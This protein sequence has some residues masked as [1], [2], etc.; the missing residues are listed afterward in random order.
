ML[1]FHPG[2]TAEELQH[3]HQI[4]KSSPGSQR[5]ALRFYRDDAEPVS[6]DAAPDF[7]VR[8][9]P[10]L[11]QRLTAWLTPFVREEYAQQEAA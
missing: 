4:L 1:H 5:V 7:G 11:E 3:V 9:T 8:I 2:T 10:E 6:I